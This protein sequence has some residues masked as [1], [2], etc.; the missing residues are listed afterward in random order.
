MKKQFTLSVLLLWIVAQ[1][2]LA[3][4]YEVTNTGSGAGSL[5]AALTAANSVPTTNGNPHVINVCT[6]G[7]YYLSP[8]PSQPVIINGPKDQ[9][10]VMSGVYFAANLQGK[11][12]E[13]NY[14]TFTGNCCSSFGS[15]FM[16]SAGC[17]STFN[18]C[19]FTT[20]SAQHQAGGIFSNGD[21][22]YINNCTFDGNYTTDAGGE[23]GGAVFNNQ[24]FMIITNSTFSNNTSVSV[25]STGGGGAV[26]N[27]GYG[28]LKVLNCTF[29]NNHSASYGGA[30]ATFSG[31]ACY[32]SN[33]IFVGN[34]AGMAGNDLWGDFISLDG[35]NIISD[36]ND[37][38]F[39]G[40]TT[41]NI[42]NV[43]ATSVIDTVLKNNG[44]YHWTHA[45]V[46]GSPAIDAG[47][48]TAAPATD[49]HGFARSGTADIG[50]AEYGAVN[51][52]ASYT[53]SI[54]EINDTCASPINRWSA[55]TTGGAAEKSAYW[56][57]N[58]SYYCGD[59]LNYQGSGIF[60]FTITDVNNCVAKDT[61]NFSVLI[62]QEPYYYFE[63]CSGDTLHHNGNIYTTAGSYTELFG[64]DSTVTVEIG[65]KQPSQIYYTLNICSGDSFVIGGHSYTTAGSYTDYFGCDST[66]YTD[67]SILTVGMPTTALTQAVS[68]AGGS[69]G[70][71]S[72][73]GGDFTVV[74]NTDTF[75]VGGLK[76]W[77]DTILDVSR[78]YTQSG[79]W[80]AEQVLYAPNTY[81][82]YGDIGTSWTP[83]SYGDQRDYIV[84]GY[85]NAVPA[86][87]LLVYE[88]N[89]PGLIDTVWVRAAAT[90]TWSLAYTGTPQNGNPVATI[91]SVNLNGTAID[92]VRLDIATDI[93]NDWMEID[94]IGLE[95]AGNSTITGLSA[96]NYN[97]VSTD[98][99]GCHYNGNFSIAD[100][101]N[102][103][104]LIA[105]A[106]TALCAGSSLSL[107]ASGANTYAWSSGQTTATI[108]STPANTTSYIVSGTDNNGC[109]GKDTV[110]VTVNNLPVINLNIP[111]VPLC[112]GMDSVVNLS[113]GLP[114]GGN[115]SG[116]IVVNNAINLLNAVA[117]TY[118]IS[119]TYTDA[120]GCTASG[121]DTVTVSIC[122]GLEE[123]GGNDI[124]FGV[125]PNP[126][127]G[128]IQYSAANI[129]GA[130]AIKIFD[131]KGQLVY[132]LKTTANGKLQGMIEL[133]EFPEGLYTVQ[134]Q[135][136][137]I[138]ISKR[139]VIAR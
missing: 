117:G 16:S 66:V 99:N 122:N 132:E 25:T 119:Y 69:N 56:T 108:S 72:L 86:A 114:A 31:G 26:K 36:V 123:T 6:G 42:V 125:Y 20:N 45:L 98:V 34:T 129:E 33:N 88:T 124:S 137:R 128:V 57:Y 133:V 65:Y 18:H 29:Y 73:G 105:Q 17:S 35:H 5:Q 89:A 135:T 28:T 1:T 102:P 30:I 23:G 131:T 76:F 38:N 47:D 96:G 10:M 48:N 112:A 118:N 138:N 49:E 53:T 14:M 67:L 71:I 95:V 32:I 111:N 19:R 54:N 62:P 94:A 83:E 82:N 55:V 127:N 84:V 3:N 80:S 139:L 100:G 37:A 75:I 92:A 60:I 13:Y 11:H 21:T 77:A 103:S 130:A 4:T 8:L 134:L 64:C 91:F 9:S 40:V 46:Q 22:V 27:H 97:Y 50:A 115:Y 51:P 24:G 41:G 121:N 113:G 79:N 70:E 110:V 109:V 87:R 44:R 104:V 78:E 136:N 101:S 90:G 85:N 74:Y 2:A 120:N 59:T 126:S 15:S 43:T 81:P 63:I 93:A 39:L 68:C 116:S 7:E 52:C 61:A 12:F 106:D 58:G 107:S